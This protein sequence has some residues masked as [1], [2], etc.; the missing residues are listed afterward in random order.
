[1][2][3]FKDIRSSSFTSY[4]DYMEALELFKIHRQKLVF[5]V[6]SHTVLGFWFKYEIVLHNLT[7]MFEEYSTIIEK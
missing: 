2:L 3:L 6:I 5:I 4:L 7:F 1:M